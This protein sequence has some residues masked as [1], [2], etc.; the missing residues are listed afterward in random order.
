MNGHTIVQSLD[1]FFRWITRIT[2][3]NLLWIGFSLLG[4]IVLGVFPATVATLAVTRKWLTGARDIH[5]GKLFT[6]TFKTEFI[7]ANIIGWLLAIIGFRLYLNYKVMLTMADT[8]PVITLFSFILVT[9]FYLLITLWVF[10]M[11]VNYKDT[12]MQYVKNAFIIGIGKLHVTLGI[13]I[14][15]FV[16]LYISLEF[17]TTIIFCSISLAAVGWNWLTLKTFNK[18]DQKEQ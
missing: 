11:I 13:M 2:I 1:T 10:P 3:V 9:F 14:W 5:I 7:V 6:E 16:V 8:L 12:I 18:F 17:P 4:F 15:L